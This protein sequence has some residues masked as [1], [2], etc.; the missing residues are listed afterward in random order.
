[1]L[2]STPHSFLETLG[3]L[4]GERSSAKDLTTCCRPRQTHSQSQRIDPVSDAHPHST[5]VSLAETITMLSRIPA[6]LPPLN[7]DLHATRRLAT[8]M[9][10][11]GVDRV[12]AIAPARVKLASD[13]HTV[14]TLDLRPGAS[15]RMDGR[16]MSITKAKSWHL[17]DTA[18]FGDGDG[19]KQHCCAAWLHQP[20]PPPIGEVPS[21][22]LEAIAR[23]GGQAAGIDGILRDA[24][25]R[26]TQATVS[27][28]NVSATIAQPCICANAR[29]DHHGGAALGATLKIYKDRNGKA[30][31]NACC[32]HAEGC[33]T[34]LCSHALSPKAQTTL[35]QL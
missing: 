27:P 12:D 21:L 30:K 31:L 34:I 15:L 2:Q 28:G 10:V 16:A 25:L 35:E 8:A 9:G 11:E 23:L 32:Q 33:N 17:V 26:L 5:M 13:T 20:Y 7:P 22:L 29:G 18:L 3:K 19:R 4:I 24:Q 1:M 6:E 14:A